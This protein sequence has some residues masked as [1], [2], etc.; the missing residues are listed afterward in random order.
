MNAK[1]PA[2]SSELPVSN[3]NSFSGHLT[4]ARFRDFVFGKFILVNAVLTIS[5][6]FLIFVYVGKEAAPVFYYA[7]TQKEASLH[8]LFAPQQY[9]SEEMPLA[10][11]WQP[12]SEVPKYSVLPLFLGTF[13]VT[14]IALLFGAPLAIG[15]ALY[16][17]EFANHGVREF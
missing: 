10:F 1:V 4:G 6:I 14:I 2:N 17:A 7:A 11:V 5:I 3:T 8:N 12:V 9:G 16:T 15:A 13:K